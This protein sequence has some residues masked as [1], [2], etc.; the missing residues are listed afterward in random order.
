MTF[1]DPNL[2]RPGTTQ[3]S[4]PLTAEEKAAAEKD[5][6]IA[7]RVYAP[8]SERVPVPPVPG[9]REFVERTD[10]AA[11]ERQSTYSQPSPGE[12]RERDWSDPTWNAELPSSRGWLGLPMGFGS[13]AMLACGALGVWFYVRR[14]RERNKPIN[15]FRRQAMQTASDLRERVPDVEDWRQ[16]ASYSVAATL[17]PIALLIWRI[18]DSRQQPPVQR[19]TE[20]DWQARLTSLKDRWSQ[21]LVA[22][23]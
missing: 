23:R 10:P 20:A 3:I 12:V 17:L 1:P 21:S 8:A 16:P 22:N 9:H 2:E 13:I 6:G 11:A 14:Q 4:R 15:R 7:E 18:M 5:P 19:V